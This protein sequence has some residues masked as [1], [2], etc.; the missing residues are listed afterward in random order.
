[1]INR[2]IQYLLIFYRRSRKYLFQ[3]T[4]PCLQRFLRGDGCISV[5][6][7]ALCHLADQRIG[8]GQLADLSVRNLRHDP[9][10][11]RCKGISRIQIMQ[12]LHA[13]PVSEGHLAHRRND[14]MR[15]QRIGRN[16][17]SRLHILEKLS[18]QIH[19]LGKIRKIIRIPVDLQK[20]QLTA[21]M[22]QL[23]R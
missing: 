6:E 11:A 14:P 15:V 18:V 9:A 7:A 1:M 10:E 8:D 23:R 13:Q 19:G 5:G 2:R 20:H 22:L 12:K 4:G 16:N 3:R 17:S 21:R